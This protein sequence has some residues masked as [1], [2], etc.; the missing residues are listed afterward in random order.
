MNLNASGTA[1]VL[2]RALGVQDWFT[3]STVTVA[4]I[5]SGIQNGVDF[6]GRIVQ[7]VRLVFW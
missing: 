6:D 4:V 1:S 2:K 7:V 3:G 5:D